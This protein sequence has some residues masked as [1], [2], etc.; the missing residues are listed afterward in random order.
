[1]RLFLL[2]CAATVVTGHQTLAQ[3]QALVPVASI[4]MPGVSG[5]IDHLAVDRDGNRLFVAALGNN[6][7]EAIDLRN[8]AIVQSARGFAEPQGLAYLSGPKQVVVANGGSG[9]VQFR[10]GA[11]LHLMAHVDLG[12]D[13]DNV[14]YDAAANRVYVAYGSALAALDAGSARRVGDVPLDAHPES[15]QLEGNGARIFVNVPGARHIAVID[16]KQMKVAT[17]WPLTA[18]EANYPMAL[19]DTGKFLFVGCRKPARVLV[20]DT[21]S[22]KTLTAIDAVGDTDD[23]FFD[24]AQKRLYVIGGEGFIDVFAVRGAALTRLAQVP[25]AAGAR[26]GLFVPEQK[27]LYV[28]IPAR[29]SQ[30]AEIRVYEARN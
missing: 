26:T 15:F 9:D 5:R 25:T 28:A 3:P 30:R 27:R 22:G 1:M 8:N 29:G 14:R 13:A 16:R 18:A 7:V 11:D 2:L 24:A 17:T 12:D 19:D 6:T 23:L 10:G 21:A 20:L 4:A